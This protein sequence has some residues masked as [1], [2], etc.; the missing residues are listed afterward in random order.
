MSLPTSVRHAELSDLVAL[1]T[2]Q[3]ATKVDVVVP[4]SAVRARD[5][6][7]ELSGVGPVVDER[8]VTLVDGVYRPTAAA[9]SQLGSKLK[10]PVGYLRWLREQQRTDFTT[11]T[12]TACSTAPRTRDSPDST[13]SGRFC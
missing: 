11:T 3:Q 6:F 5:G 8:G 4:A 13:T 2:R 7:V 10:I 9:D 1:L 12:S